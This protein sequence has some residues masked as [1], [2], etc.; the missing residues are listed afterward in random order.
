MAI[1][2]L[3][4]NNNNYFV[5]A[6]IIISRKFVNMGRKNYLFVCYE[7]QIDTELWMAE[8]AMTFNGGSHS[9]TM[10]GKVRRRI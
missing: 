10:E 8:G 3:H 4:T 2:F 1:N 7:G 6:T 5:I 9:R